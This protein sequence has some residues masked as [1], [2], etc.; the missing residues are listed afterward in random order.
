MRLNDS[1]S[2]L[3]DRLALL[4][5]MLLLLLT[6][7][8]SVILHAKAWDNADASRFDFGTA[9]PGPRELEDQTQNAIKREYAS[10]WKNMAQAV[11][12]NR[13]DL[14]DQNFVGA[15]RDQLRRQIDQQKKNGMSS[16][17]NDRS[18]KV[19]FIFYS[20]EGT[21]IELH[22]TVEM[23]HQTLDG[24]K[25]IHSASETRKYVVVFTLVEDRWKVRTLQ[26]EQ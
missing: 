7:F 4:L 16:K 3:S 14:V 20:P 19:E 8:P 15:Q 13:S 12:Q 11:E 2:I 23:E 18:H 21:A 10:A 17:L 22:D 9:N 5:L 24:G 26:Q 25:Q 6:S 1:T